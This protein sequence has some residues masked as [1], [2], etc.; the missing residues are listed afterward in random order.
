MIDVPVS[1]RLTPGRTA[2]E[3]SEMRPVMTPSCA[4]HVAATSQVDNAA[5]RTLVSFAMAPPERTNSNVE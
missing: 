4:Q 5:I 1:D 3:A 2:P